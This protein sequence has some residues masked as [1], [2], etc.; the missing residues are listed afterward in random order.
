MPAPPIF[1]HT[2]CAAAFDYCSA[3]FRRDVTR[4]LRRLIMRTQ[5]ARV[6]TMMPLIR[7]LL[8]FIFHALMLAMPLDADA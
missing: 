2:R 1:R 6:A 8:F 3:Y 4:V 7:A 5:N